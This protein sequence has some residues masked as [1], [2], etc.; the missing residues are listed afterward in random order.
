VSKE[1]KLKPIRLTIND[2]LEKINLNPLS[3]KDIKITNDSITIYFKNKKK[4]VIE[5]KN[6]YYVHW[7]ANIEKLQSYY[8]L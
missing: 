1:I 7:R 3:I 5:R 2:N 6:L 8:G 4:I